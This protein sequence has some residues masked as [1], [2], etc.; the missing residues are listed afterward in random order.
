MQD[1]EEEDA[2]SE[3]EGEEESGSSVF[4]SAEELLEGSDDSDSEVGGSINYEFI[5]A[6]RGAWAFDFP[7]SLPPR[8][9]IT[10]WFPKS[11]E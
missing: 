6:E 9:S 8:L 11:Y 5:V 3:V 4:D 10:N 1:D 7:C 2:E